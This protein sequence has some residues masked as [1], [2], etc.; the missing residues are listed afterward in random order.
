LR[1]DIIIMHGYCRH[2]ASCS[3]YHTWFMPCFDRLYWFG[4]ESSGPEISTLA[5]P[6]N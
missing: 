3:S 1:M 4:Y 5:K 2:V 6:K